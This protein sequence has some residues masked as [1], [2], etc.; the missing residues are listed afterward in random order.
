MP[1][2]QTVEIR[3]PR[4]RQPYVCLIEKNDVRKKVL[5]TLEEAEQVALKILK[6]V[7]K[8]K[9]RKDLP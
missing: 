4:L 8:E 6:R 1:K 9:T 2:K 5:M 3:F 7:E